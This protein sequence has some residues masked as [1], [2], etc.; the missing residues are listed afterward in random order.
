M[1]D[2]LMPHHI[3]ILNSFK[4]FNTRSCVGMLLKGARICQFVPGKVM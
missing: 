2:Q 4:S 1:L 3:F